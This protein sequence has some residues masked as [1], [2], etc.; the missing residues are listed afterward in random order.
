MN[1]VR[2]SQRSLAASKCPVRGKLSK[3]SSN[4]DGHREN[5]NI[6]LEQRLGATL[7]ITCTSTCMQFKS[8]TNNFET[9]SSAHSIGSSQNLS[10]VYDWNVCRNWKYSARPSKLLVL[11]AKITWLIIPKG[12]DPCQKRAQSI[13]RSKSTTC[14]LVVVIDRASPVW[15]SFQNS[16]RWA[17]CCWHPAGAASPAI[18]EFLNRGYPRRYISH[19]SEYPHLPIQTYFSA[20]PCFILSLPSLGMIFDMIPTTCGD[21]ISICVT[22][23]KASC[24]QAG[25]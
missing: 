18:Q 3:K 11:P 19:Y 21:A 13:T 5:V 12:C 9:K 15:G 4:K 22:E 2:R 17:W 6:D 20:T 14:F 24:N 23:M 7:T 1:W 25:V 8:R 16:T 10:S